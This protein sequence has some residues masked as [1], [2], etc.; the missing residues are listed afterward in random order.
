MKRLLLIVF[1][2][3]LISCNSSSEVIKS[4]Y[5]KQQ[6]ECP[7]D[8]VCSF[9]IEQNKSLKLVNDN[10]MNLYP[11]ILDGDNIV[12]T[13]EY[14]RN[15]IPDTADGHYIEQLILEVDPNKLELTLI[16]KELENVK[17][18]FARFCY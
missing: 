1:S 5:T 9:K 13:F 7:S 14:K 11:E 6:T 15:E 4:S 16:N 12:L 3:I 2:L 10:T 8:G 17:L 18:L